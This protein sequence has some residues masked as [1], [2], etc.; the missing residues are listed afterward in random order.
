MKKN[1]VIEDINKKGNYFKD[2]I[3]KI[4]SDNENI[5]DFTGAPWMPFIN[6]KKGIK[7]K[8]L[9]SEFYKHLIRRKVFSHPYHHSYI[10]YRHTYEDL[11]YVSGAIEESIKEVKKI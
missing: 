1:N 9:R 6:F 4:I 8:I 5:A 3:N 7:K 2:K 10:C 11:D